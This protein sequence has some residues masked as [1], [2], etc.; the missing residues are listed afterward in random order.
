MTMRSMKLG[1]EMNSKREPMMM[2][3]PVLL[4]K[5]KGR[6]NELVDDGEVYRAKTI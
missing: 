5:G 1:E 6:T 3:I 4:T 2:K